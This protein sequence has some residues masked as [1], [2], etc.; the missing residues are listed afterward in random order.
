MIALL[1]IDL[2]TDFLPDGALPVAGGDEV[3]P[4]ANRLLPGYELVVATQDWHP[5]DHKS[6]ASQHPG[7]E[8]GE[9][10]ILDGLEQILWPD[11]CI[12]HTPGAAFAA[13]LDTSRI[14]H[15]VY[16]GTD[17]NIDSYSGFFD[18][19]HRR[20]TGLAEYLREQ[21]A[22]EVHVMGLATDYCVKFTVLDALGLGF[23]TVLL[24]EG[25]RGV[26]LQPG[27]CQRAIDEMRT[28]GAEIR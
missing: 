1:L 26:E 6:F 3:I 24:S 5:A 23:H 27:D 20:S 15:V 9:R 11:H 17:R 8:V 25:V 2:Q 7:R 4:V 10:I 21:G 13:G 16:K 14:D 28:A 18:N 22:G 19:A 12:Q